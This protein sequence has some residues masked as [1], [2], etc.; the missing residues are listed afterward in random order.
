M[1]VSRLRFRRAGDLPAGL[2]RGA[3]AQPRSTTG[4][5][6]CRAAICG[7]CAD[8]ERSAFTAL[9]T[10]LSGRTARSSYVA[11]DAVVEQPIHLVFVATAATRRPCAPAHSDRRWRAQRRRRS[12]R[13]Y[14]GAAGATYFTNAVTEVV[15]GDR[16]RRRSLQGA[17]RERVGVPR[18][19][20][21]TC[22]PVARARASRRTISLGGAIVRNDITAR[23]RR[24]G[25]RLHAERPVSG[26]RRRSSSTTTR[27]STTPSRTATATSSTRASSDGRARGVFNGKIFVRPGRAED[28]RQADQQDAA[29]LRRRADQHQAAAR[30]LRRRR[31][32]HARRDR[33]ASS[34]RTRFLPAGARHRRWRTR[35]PADPRVRQ[36]HRRP[37]QGRA[38]ARAARSALLERIAGPMR[39]R[40]QE[41]RARDS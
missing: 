15:V 35:G 17:A 14:V 6:R 38:A 16:R 5:E 28:R 36:R 21:C 23:A 12:S 40:G 8:F 39:R 41:R 1:A 27:R 3:L 29:A 4:A 20:A 13:R 18:R 19:H 25:Q 33:R 22:T 10:A 2:R 30:D 32:V 37:H 24:R 7:Q 26:R 9:N 31:E 34:T 11:R